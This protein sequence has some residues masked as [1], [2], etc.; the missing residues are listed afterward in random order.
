MRMK[1]N[2]VRWSCLNSSEVRQGW[3][4]ADKCGRGSTGLSV[5][6]Q[7]PAA[8]K[9]GRGLAAHSDTFGRARRSSENFVEFGPPASAWTSAAQL[10]LSCTRSEQVLIHHN[11]WFNF[12]Q[13]FMS[14][15]ELRLSTTSSSGLFR[16]CLGSECDRLS[17]VWWNLN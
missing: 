3:T 1:E 16:G 4:S 6:A 9:N 5:V 7:G 8:R 2:H 17:K 12:N 13:A 14:S 11:D 15:H 10:F